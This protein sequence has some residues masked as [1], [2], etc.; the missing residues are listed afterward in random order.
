MKFGK[1][2]KYISKQHEV[3]VSQIAEDLFVPGNILFSEK[4]AMKTTN[5]TQVTI[6]ADGDENTVLTISSFLQL[7]STVIVISDSYEYCL[8]QLSRHDLQFSEFAGAC[9]Q[10]GTD[11]GALL[12]AT[13]LFPTVMVRNGNTPSD[14]LF[15]A[16][17]NAIR[18]VDLASNIV[19]TIVTSTDLGQISGIVFDTEHV[20]TLF[21]TSGRYIKRV[22]AI[23]GSEPTISDVYLSNGSPG[24]DDGG[25]ETATFDEPMGVI[26]VGRGV[27]LMSGTKDSGRLRVVDTVLRKVSSVCTGLP[28]FQPGLISECNIPFPRAQVLIGNTVYIGGKSAIYTLNGK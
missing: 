24:L 6:L 2:D 14:R 5:G 13:F 16:D 10:Q 22:S 4:L 8:H 9:E 26:S 20:E 28:E 25:F 15:V 17:D 11:D 21:V 27:Y 18:Y 3:P 7:N 1:L 23:E 19:G 12:N